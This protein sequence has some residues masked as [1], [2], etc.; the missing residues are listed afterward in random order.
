MKQV[1]LS[2]ALVID[3][4]GRNLPFHLET[5]SSKEVGIPIVRFSARYQANKL[6]A[7]RLHL[8]G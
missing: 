2:P 6:I 8:K 3:A 7:I 5:I 1:L 4:R